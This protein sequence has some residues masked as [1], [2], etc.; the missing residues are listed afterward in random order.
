[1]THNTG[2]RR[3]AV[4]C[5]NSSLEGTRHSVLLHRGSCPVLAGSHRPAGGRAPGPVIPPTCDTGGQH[6]PLR[7]GGTA[8]SAPA[9]PK[10]AGVVT[11]IP[12]ELESGYQILSA[13]SGAAAVIHKTHLLM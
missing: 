1:M 10:A 7:G 13:L 8:P 2:T 5:L 11:S 6:P 9:V 12:A 3:C 4:C